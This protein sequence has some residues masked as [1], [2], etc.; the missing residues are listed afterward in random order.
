MKIN[1]KRLRLLIKEVCEEILAEKKRKKKKS[2]KRKKRHSLPSL[3]PYF[4]YNISRD[5]NS[6]YGDFSADFGDAGGGGE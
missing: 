2:S 1:R 3:Y 6:D 5:D 4:G